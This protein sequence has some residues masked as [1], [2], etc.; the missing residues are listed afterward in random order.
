M[1]CQLDDGRRR[2]RNGSHAWI[3]TKI[4][5][6]TA[7]SPT[8]GG[9]ENG[10]PPRNRNVPTAILQGSPAYPE[11][12]PA[13]KCGIEPQSRPFQGRVLTTATTSAGWCGRRESS[14]DLNIGDVARSPLR[15]ARFEMVRR[16]RVERAQPKA[17]LLQSAGLTDVQPAQ[18]AKWLQR[19]ESNGLAPVYETGER[20]VLFSASMA[21]GGG[22]EPRT[23]RYPT[24]SRRVASHLAAPS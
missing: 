17:A 7:G 2:L 23:F 24:F 8:V 12:G 4:G 21:E 20:P 15:H 10:G 3:R 1:S 18:S 22:I 11:R 13:P 9:H 6:L 14:P 19:P 16:A 5:R